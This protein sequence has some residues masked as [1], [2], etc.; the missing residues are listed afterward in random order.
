MAAYLNAR[1]TF[2]SAVRVG[3]AGRAI[4]LL[5]AEAVD[6]GALKG[7]TLDTPWDQDKNRI[8]TAIRA[9]EPARRD[10]RYQ[11]QAGTHAPAGSRHSHCRSGSPAEPCTSSTSSSW[12]SLVHAVVRPTAVQPGLGRALLSLCP[13][14]ANN[15]R[16]SPAHFGSLRTDARVGAVKVPE[17]ARARARVG[18]RA[19]TTLARLSLRAPT[20]VGSG[21]ARS[22]VANA[23]ARARVPRRAGIL[24]H[25]VDFVIAAAIVVV[26]VGRP[27]LRTGVGSD[28]VK[29]RAWSPV[30]THRCRYRHAP[31]LDTKHA[32]RKES[33]RDKKKETHRGS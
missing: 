22:A 28:A 2:G 11:R 27:G 30:L 25:D 15:V 12:R 4:A 1:A 9:Q 17:R 16:H 32:Q 20:A 21:G 5:L 6:A 31:L 18:A 26:L 7:G 14:V 13:A 8:S 19:L 23:T 33:A 29:D 24:G 10:T 3:V